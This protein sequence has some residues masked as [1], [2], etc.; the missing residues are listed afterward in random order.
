[1]LCCVVLCCV[2]MFCVMFHCDM[3]FCTVLYDTVYYNFYCDK[4]FCDAISVTCTFSSCVYSPV[5]PYTFPFFNSSFS[6]LY[7][8]SLFF[9]AHFF[10]SFFS[11]LFRPYL[12]YHFIRCTTFVYLFFSTSGEENQFYILS[13]QNSI[14]FLVYKQELTKKNFFFVNIGK[15]YVCFK[16]R[17]FCSFSKYINLKKVHVRSY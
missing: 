14:I 16:F 4:Q 8:L 10:S 3:M 13:P 9:S 2:V 17:W 15:N 7:F 11:L 1:M 6:S 5:W 12:C